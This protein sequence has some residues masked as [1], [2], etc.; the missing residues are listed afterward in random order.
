MAFL[1]RL[2]DKIDQLN[3]AIGNGAAWLMPFMAVSAFSV[4][5]LRYV[6]DLGWIWAKD[7]IVYSHGALFMLGIAYTFLHDAHVRIDIFYSRMKPKKR[8]LVNLIGIFGLLLP[9]SLLLLI[10]SQPYVWAS[11]KVWE[12]SPEVNGMPGV[13]VLK[14]IIFILPILLFLQSFSMGT[15]CFLV[16]AGK[17]IFSSSQMKK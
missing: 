13:F 17:K 6:F 11:W 12:D 9:F 4:T 16:L 1:F 8:A 14:T 15:R 3:T 2:V 7:M 5:I 10:Y